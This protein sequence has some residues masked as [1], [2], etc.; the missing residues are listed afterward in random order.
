WMINSTAYR[1]HRTPGQYRR[2]R[3]FNSTGFSVEGGCHL[4]WRIAGYVRVQLQYYFRLDHPDHVL[5]TVFR[6][7]AVA[8]IVGKYSLMVLAPGKQNGAVDA[9]LFC[10]H[11]RDIGY[12]DLTDPTHGVS[13]GSIL[14]ASEFGDEQNILWLLKPGAEIV[15]SRGQV[16]FDG[17]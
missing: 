3:V 17:P 4:K 14:S 10:T 5:D 8:R 11:S 2:I 15:T 7:L 1:R 6:C 13:R 12:L 9:Y 16:C